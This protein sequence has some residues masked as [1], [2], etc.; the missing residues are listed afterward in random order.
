[1]YDTVGR[2]I[3]DV[4]GQKSKVW[5]DVNSQVVGSSGPGSNS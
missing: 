1:M 5:E 2:Y 3:G 4:V